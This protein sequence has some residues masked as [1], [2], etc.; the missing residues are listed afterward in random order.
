MSIC[1]AVLGVPEFMWVV[2]D[3]LRRMVV[4]AGLCDWGH[5]CRPPPARALLVEPGE[6]KVNSSLVP[7]DWLNARPRPN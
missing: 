1:V 7:R 4:G 5:C 6:L 3:T 2:K